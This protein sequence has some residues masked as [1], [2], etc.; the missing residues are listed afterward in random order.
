MKRLET[1]FG[2]LLRE[3][4][5]KKGLTQAELGADCNLDRT[6]IS[7]LERGIRQPTIGTLFKLAEV[8]DIK[9]SAILKQL[10]N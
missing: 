9:P 10:E 8:L 2:E 5:T 6:Y 1:R 7:L 3:L 4:R